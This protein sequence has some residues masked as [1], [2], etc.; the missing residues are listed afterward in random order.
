MHVNMF[1]V[2]L[3]VANLE[4]WPKVK[5]PFF[6]IHLDIQIKPINTRMITFAA[7]DLMSEAP[8]WISEG[9]TL[10]EIHSK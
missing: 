8:S 5:I 1:T 6:G 7:I 3:F 4:F 10:C 9:T 2:D